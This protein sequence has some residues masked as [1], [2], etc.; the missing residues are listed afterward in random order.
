MREYA[1]Q[2]GLQPR[3]RP[4]ARAHAAP[5]EPLAR[6][7][8]AG[9]RAHRPQARRLAAERDRRRGRARAPRLPR[10]PAPRPYRGGDRARARATRIASFAE[11]RW[12]DEPAA[13]SRGA[14]GGVRFGSRLVDSRCVECRRA[15]PRAAFAPIRRIGGARGCYYGNGALAPA[16]LLDLLVGGAGLRRGRREP[17]GAAARGRRSTSGASR[18]IEP[19]RLLRLRAEMRVPGRAWLQFEVDGDGAPLDRPADGDLRSG[20]RPRPRVLVRALA[21]APARLRRDAARDASAR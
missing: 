2:R 17:G 1:R 4:R 18:R 16:R 8:H 21:A 12:S 7:R 6:A 3:A 13:A 5:V 10:D 15:H 20:R 14:G 19:D 11:T 9:L